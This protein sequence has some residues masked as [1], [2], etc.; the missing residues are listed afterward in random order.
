MITPPDYTLHGMNRY[1]VSA[2][3]FEYFVIVN[4]GR[5]YFPNLHLKNSPSLFLFLFRLSFQRSSV[6][7]CRFLTN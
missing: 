5:G 6:P 4:A 3:F 1:S 2:L 7:Y